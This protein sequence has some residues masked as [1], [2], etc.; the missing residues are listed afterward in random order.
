MRRKTRLCGG[1]EPSCIAS[2][3]RQQLISVAYRVWVGTNNRLR[4]RG[5]LKKKI[6]KS[7]LLIREPKQWAAKNAVGSHCQDFAVVF[8]ECT[9]HMSIQPGR[10]PVK[11]PQSHPINF[12]LTL[13]HHRQANLK[14][15][16]SPLHFCA[17]AYWCLWATIIS[18]DNSNN[19]KSQ[20]CPSVD[21]P[22]AKG[23]DFSALVNNGH[24]S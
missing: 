11:A 4:D 10:L 17:K 21:A 7:L 23:T 1:A 2:W 20:M 16:T 19:K 14:D 6:W 24:M 18:L 13:L 22:S 8:L 3:A 9:T 5:E 15:W 12:W